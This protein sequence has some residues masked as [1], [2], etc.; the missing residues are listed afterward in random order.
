MVSVVVRCDK[1][2]DLDAADKRRGKPRR[3]RKDS[4]TT[5]YELNIRLDQEQR[6]LMGGK[7]K[8]TRVVYA[9][10]KKEDLANQMR[11]FENDVGAKLRAAALQA[12]RAVKGA[13][14]SVSGVER[15]YLESRAGVVVSE[16]T[17]DGVVLAG[18]CCLRMPY[19]FKFDPDGVKP[20]DGLG[21][22][23]AVV[24]GDLLAVWAFDDSRRPRYL[25]DGM[26]GGMT[27]IGTFEKEV[28]AATFQDGVLL[29]VTR[30]YVD[31]ILEE[32]DGR[33]PDR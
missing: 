2:Y 32:K 21:Q 17:Q 11:D 27:P 29:I 18:Q 14:D 20:V 23:G 13:D 15:P 30:D 8:Y 7:R 28:G 12:G 5:A 16:R 24:V 6:D 4:K 26:E 22:H 9:K 33:A 3:R 19:A 10:N 1:P 31:K 25:I